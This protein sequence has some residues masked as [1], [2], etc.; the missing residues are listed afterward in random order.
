M[1]GQGIDE[2]KRK[3]FELVPQPSEP[4]EAGSEELPLPEFLVYRPRPRRGRP[5]RIL[6]TDRGF[7][8]EGA[9]PA[10]AELDAA[11]RAAGARKGA[12][13]EVGDQTFELA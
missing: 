3:L 13:V 7:R 6:R 12:E 2:L 5:Y 1:T 4:A 11:L 10:D 8:V 9:A